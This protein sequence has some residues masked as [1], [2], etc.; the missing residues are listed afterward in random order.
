MGQRPIY[1]PI[2]VP[3][4]NLRDPPP[5]QALT[6][7]A[8]DCRPDFARPSG[9]LSRLG[10]GGGGKGQIRPWLPWERFC[11]QYGLIFGSTVNQSV[12][13]TA[14]DRGLGA[15]PQACF[16][17]FY[18]SK[19]NATAASRTDCHLLVT[20]PRRQAATSYFTNIRRRQLPSSAADGQLQITPPKRNSRLIADCSVSVFGFTASPYPAW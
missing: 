7:R 19:R 14:S 1:R 16:G 18:T 4:P 13:S 3:R 15:A 12:S 2:I 5:L 17:S 10:K 20:S 9:P 6:P 8:S 11:A